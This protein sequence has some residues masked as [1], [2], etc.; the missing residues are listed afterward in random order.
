MILTVMFSTFCQVIFLHE[1]KYYYL[2]PDKN[3]YLIDSA[4]DLNYDIII[5]EL[6]I[7]LVVR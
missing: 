4:F 3:S 5:N 7:F 2:Y 6:F 1:A